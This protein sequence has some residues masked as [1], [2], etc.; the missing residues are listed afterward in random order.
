MFFVL[1]L[2]S[3]DDDNSYSLKTREQIY[4]LLKLMSI[5]IDL[6]AGSSS[7]FFSFFFLNIR[8]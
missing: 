2:L 3:I 5:F 7:F 4:K 1:L 6:A 8:Q